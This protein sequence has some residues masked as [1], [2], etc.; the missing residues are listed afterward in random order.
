MNDLKWMNGTITN[1]KMLG[2]GV[3]KIGEIGFNG[4][5]I[6]KTLWPYESYV[7]YSME[8]EFFETFELEN[9]PMDS[10]DLQVILYIHTTTIYIDNRVYHNGCNS[11]TISI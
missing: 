9:F 7:V 10:Q 2:S 6:K 8:G 3:A 1:Q 5:K 4:M 11:Y